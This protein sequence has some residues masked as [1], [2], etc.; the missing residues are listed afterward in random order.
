FQNAANATRTQLSSE[1]AGQ[2]RDLGAALP[3]R[4]DQLQNLSAQIYGGNYQAERDR[5]MTAV[6]QGNTL[7]PL[8]RFINQLGGLIPGAGGTSSSTQPVYRGGIFSDRRLKK[9]IERIST[10]KGL[11]WYR[12]EYI[13][14]EESRSEEHTSELKSR[15]NIVWRRRHAK[16]TAS[17]L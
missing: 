3:A 13:W 6:D 7:D 4:S 11:P 8:N 17:E 2:G 14:G 1:F 10:V 9:N 16:K 15:E 12:F 5:Q